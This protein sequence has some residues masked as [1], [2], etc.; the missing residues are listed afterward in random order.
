M[1]TT[2]L[3]MLSGV[4]FSWAVLLLLKLPE[5]YY[6]FLYWG[7]DQN[8]AQ[9]IQ[10]MWIATV[11]TQLRRFWMLIMIVTQ[12]YCDN[13]DKMNAKFRGLKYELIVFGGIRN[14][15]WYDSIN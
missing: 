13:K 14:D 8:H 12:I 2:F 4:I 6:D 7:S 5:A 11:K 1:P 9:K 15:S 10:W 3:R